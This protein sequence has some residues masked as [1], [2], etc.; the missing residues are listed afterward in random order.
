MKK[1]ILFSILFAIKTSFSFGQTDQAIVNSFKKKVKQV[2]SVFSTSPIVLASQEFSESKSGRIYYLLK[3]E[4]VKESSYDIEKT[5]SLVSPYTGYIILTTRVLSNIRSG[6]VQSKGADG[7]LLGIYGFESADEANEVKTFGSCSST[8]I[9][10]TN[11]NVDNGCT[12]DIKISYAY[13]DKVWVFKGVETEVYNS[14]DIKNGILNKYF[15]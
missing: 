3:F 6:N 4:K 13:Q 12:G 5:N 1:L 8:M 7:T 15:K 11:N 14:V 10:S 2:D 9:G